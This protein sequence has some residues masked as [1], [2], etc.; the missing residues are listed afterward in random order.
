MALVGGGVALVWHATADLSGT[1]DDPSVD[2]HGGTYYV[3]R[4]RVT[5]AEYVVWRMGD[6]VGG[7][8]RGDGWL[9]LL[10]A[11]RC[12]HW[13]SPLVPEDEQGPAWCWPEANTRSER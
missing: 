8:L 1:V 7:T 12:Q 13:Q 9:R 10:G 4:E 2:A 5:V 6:R 3:G 11:E